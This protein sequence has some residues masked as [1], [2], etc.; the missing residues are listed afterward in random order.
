MMVACHIHAA[1]NT[2]FYTHTG[3]VVMQVGFNTDASP[4]Q[5]R[6]ILLLVSIN[7]VGVE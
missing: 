1:L 5:P 2:F 6:F 3:T 7:V 4:R